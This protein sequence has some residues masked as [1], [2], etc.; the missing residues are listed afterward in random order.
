MTLVEPSNSE[1]IPRYTAELAR[2]PNTF[3]DVV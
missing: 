3:A 2:A 1:V